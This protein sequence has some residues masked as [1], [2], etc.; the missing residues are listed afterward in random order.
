MV[1]ID[2]ICNIKITPN[3]NLIINILNNNIINNTIN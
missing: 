2:R 1:I 3:I